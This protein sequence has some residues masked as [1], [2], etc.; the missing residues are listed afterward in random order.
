M[1]GGGRHTVLTVAN[2][3]IIHQRFLDMRI[4]HHKVKRADLRAWAKA[5]AAEQG[6][7]SF[8]AS[9]GWMDKFCARFDIVKRHVSNL[10]KYNDFTLVEKATVFLTYLRSQIQ[11]V[12]S[13]NT[14]LADE[15]A[16]YMD[17][18]CK[19]TLDI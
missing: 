3:K 8:K 13:A 1:D 6:V 2:E 9:P 10:C 4:A 15:T 19:T 14:V 17:D 11:G 16:V 12:A 7:A 18:P 5:K